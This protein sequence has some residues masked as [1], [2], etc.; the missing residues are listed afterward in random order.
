METGS[1]EVNFKIGEDLSMQ[2]MMEDIIRGNA[3]MDRKEAL[4]Q[5]ISEWMSSPKRRAMLD[6]MRYYRGEH[7]ILKRRRTVL[8]KDGKPVEI[9]N[10][11]NHRVVDNQYAKM[12]AQK[13]NYLLGRPLVFD[14]ADNELEQALTS[15]F[16]RRFLRLLRRIGED[17]LNCGVGWLYTYLDDRGGMCFVRLMP[18]EIIPFW[19]D[20]EQMR[21]ELAIR[22]YETEEYF[23][24]NK[25]KVQKAEIY[26]PEGIE[27]YVLKQGR[28]FED[29]DNPA[30]SPYIIRMEKG[31][32]PV[33]LG[34]GSVP[35]IPFRCNSA[36]IPLI[37]KVKGLQDGLN[38]ILSDFENN[39]QEDARNTIL[40]LKNYDGVD[41]AEF[42]HNLAAFGAVKVK[43]VDGNPG[44]V[45]S[46]R[47]NID[48]ENYRVILDLLKK[49]ITENSMGYDAKDQ[50]LMGTPN[51]MNIQ[52]M[53]SDIDLDA[54]GMETEFQAA[55]EE[56]LGL[57][58]RYF[59][60]TGMGDFMP[61]DVKL[62]FNRD[63]LMNESEVMDSLYKGGLRLSNETLVRQV[64]WV[65]DP[66]QEIERLRT[67]NT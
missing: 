4:A 25:K 57:A 6:G 20:E 54:N 42:R 36:S 8:G 38:E 62:V 59:S 65:N 49:A 22:V 5:E 40:V 45:E 48:S 35:L 34:W 39:M 43:S 26:T 28:L 64:P 32:G 14:T 67:D 13:A 53:Y 66:A 16:D 2:T 30:K 15:V 10:L 61:G 52:S 31:Q 46:L 23:G 56:L 3:P 58:C 44:G 21:L 17:A 12:V 29:E 19:S 11:P 55:F 24:K 1:G 27:R 60:S 50:R 18:W 7:D 9:K 63:M 33:S 47:V 51:Q 41:L 37:S